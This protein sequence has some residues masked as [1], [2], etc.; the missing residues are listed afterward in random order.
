[1]AASI[2]FT[3][4]LEFNKLTQHFDQN[5]DFSMR[6]MFAEDS[7]RFESFTLQAAGITLD[8][9]KNRINHNTLPL[10]TALANKQAL[11]CAISAMFSGEL[12]NKS[13]NRP[14][15][16][17]A[18]RNFSEDPVYVD[19]KDVMPEVRATLVKMKE[20]CWRIRNQH[21]RGFNK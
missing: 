8:Y 6:Q 3:Q 19:G 21:W 4:T 15:L 2:P 10:L 7:K 9:S 17:T 16:H 18:L 13:E 5:Q 12:I 20:F 11:P 14:A 1:M